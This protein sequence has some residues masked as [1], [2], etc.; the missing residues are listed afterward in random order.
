[1]LTKSHHETKEILTRAALNRPAELPAVVQQRLL[2]CAAM[3][4]EEV[5]SKLGT[6][7]RGL[8]RQA[9]E[10]SRR[11]YGDNVVVSGR[12]ITLVNRLVAAFVNPFTLILAVL[13]VIS[14]LTDMTFASPDERSPVTVL[15]ISAMVLMSGVLRF[16]QETRSGN[17]AE[18]LTN[19]I[20][21]TT[22][23]VRHEDGEQER[24]M[25]EAVV[26]DL[27]RLAA[28]DMIP[29]DMRIL[30]AKDLFLSESALTGES[31]H[32]EKV[33]APS[34]LDS[35]HVLDYNNLAFLGTNVVSGSGLGIVL[36]TGQ[37]TLF[38][39]VAKSLEEKP[40]PTSFEKGVNHVSAVLIRFMLI[41]VPI[42]FLIS[43]LTKGDWLQAGLLSISLAVGL[44]PEMLPMIVTTSLAKGAVNLSKHRV[45]IKN[46]N[47]IQNLGSIDILCT[48]KTG[49]LTQDRVALEYHLDLMGEENV[50]VLRHAYLNSYFQTG[51]RNLMDSAI[52]EKTHEEEEHRPDALGR[53]KDRYE[54]VDE[55]P[56]DFERRRMSVVVRDKNDKT[57]M[58]TKGALEEM[59][60][61]CA[62]AQTDET[63]V[64][65][66]DEDVVRRIRDDVDDFNDKGLRVLLIAQRTNPPP[67]GAFGV[68]DEKDMVLIGYLAFLDPPK[69]STKGAIAALQDHGVA[70][71]ILTGDNEKVSRA[72]CKMVGLDVSRIVTGDEVEAMDDATLAKTAGTTTVFARLA[73]VQK[74]R[75]VS[76]LRQQGRRVGYMGDGIND[77]TALKDADVGIS[78]DTGVDI[79]KESADVILLEKDLMVLE[80][81]IVE[82]RKTYANM[83]KYIK[84]T[85]S[86]N[87]GNVLSM[88]IAAAFLPFLP[89]TAI[90][91]LILNLIYDISCASLPWDHVDG[92]YLRQPRSWDAGSIS[93]FMVWIG[94]V[95]SLFDIMAYAALFYW[96]GPA[97]TGAPFSQLAGPEQTALFIAV[98]QAGWMV[99]SMWTQTLV[100]HMIRTAK[101]PFIESR[102]SAP[103]MALTAA[104]MA[105]LTALPF[106]PL[107]GLLKLAPLPASFFLLLAAVVVTYMLLV[108]A[109]KYAF[110]RR[111]RVWL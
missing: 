60:A 80:E 46:L 91:I 48:D 102:A 39:Q 50:R 27:V 92:D 96:I 76:L 7:P 66:L 107:S 24:V 20:V 84:M 90:Q 18:R 56:F 73:P 57:Q 85:A 34:S 10:K 28:G 104:G 54:K 83:I 16:I 61:V 79:A 23:I 77:V 3:A 75:I 26:G 12:R 93:R 81:G 37:D 106:S 35:A 2:D 25:E 21:N 49:T 103:V 59:L 42:V 108:S 45:I 86:S 6:G 64:I 36:A 17:A 51:L 100:I 105:L 4:P 52:I 1:M 94:P 5:L 33:S 43:G 53:L 72:I 74:S 38:G 13:A 99:I 62:Y 41:M 97:V 71:K 70:V 8:D 9:V 98:F 55:I 68:E 15:I 44:T 14:F 31:A 82:G 19:M 101:V 29:A 58:I 110:I 87:F 32:A 78:V 30:Q 69:L 67:A 47:S 65:P 22:A 11:L 89:M 63:T 40:A 95:S 109:A 111:Y 88:L